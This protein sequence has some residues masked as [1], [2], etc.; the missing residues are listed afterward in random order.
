MANEEQLKILSQGVAAWNTWRMEN[1]YEIIDLR[2]ANLNGKNLCEVN[3]IG[4]NLAEANLGSAFFSCAY[5]NG[6]NMQDANFKKANLFGANLNGANLSKANL[7]RADISGADL[8]KAILLE[9]KISWATLNYACL[10]GANLSGARL[11]RSDLSEANLSK[12][13]LIGANL[14]GAILINTNF[15]KADLTGCKVYGISTWDLKLEDTIQENLIITPPNE[16]IITVD[17]LEVA[18]F[19]YLLLHNEKIRHVIDTI[20]SKVV[21]ILGRFSPERKVVLDAI[22]EELRKRDYVPILFDFDKPKSRDSTETVTMLA[23]MSRFIIADI[24]DPKSIPLEL[25]AIVPDIAVPVQPLLAQGSDE[26]SMFRDLRRKN[27]WVLQVHIYK[28]PE[29]LCS[30]LSEKVIAPAEAKALELRK[31]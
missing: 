5:L 25:Q 9:A 31:M 19:I 1:P 12:A 24:T 28:D 23:R 14:T 29:D 15:R 16:S 6:A 26:F 3:F 4:A 21:L 11:D 8:T 10:I 2:V 30:S 20:T 17:N 7:F 27:H 18:Q 13:N 22:R